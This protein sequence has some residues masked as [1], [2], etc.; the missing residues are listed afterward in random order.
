MKRVR[1]VALIAVGIALS[2]CASIDV[3]SR[4]ASFEAPQAEATAQS[5]K[6]VGSQIRVPQSLRVSE[7]NLYYP[8]GDIVWR[9]DPLGDRYAQVQA[10]FEDSLARATVSGDGLV[11][12]LLDIEV[13]RFHALSEKA[14]YT[15][16]GVY[17]IE[18]TM[19]FL[20]PE[21]RQ[22]VAAPRKVKADL[23]AF[24]G[25]R[26]IAAERNGLT[27]KKRITEHL[28]GVLRRELHL[29]APAASPKVADPSLVS[30]N[31]AP[32]TA[33]RNTNGLF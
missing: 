20:N 10:I 31:A 13:R 27:Q 24:G 7:A 15:V 25:S 33:S 21:T 1:L 14:R 17:S 9:G 8:P 26:A 32:L 22:P 16:G 6:V 3:A 29:D 2:A 4:N 12:V 28:T 11:P 19:N 23:K 18:F 30:R 5:M